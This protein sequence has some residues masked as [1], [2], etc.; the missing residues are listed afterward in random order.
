[1]I[2]L[3]HADD[4]GALEAA[5]ADLQLA[6]AD[7]RRPFA[8]VDGPLVTAMRQGDVILIDELNLAE[9]S[10]VE[11]LNRCLIKGLRHSCCLQAAGI[12]SAVSVTAKRTFIP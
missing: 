9:D 4:I 5:V 11:R 7:A 6:A 3:W 8:W 2:R 10:V 12:C 1:M